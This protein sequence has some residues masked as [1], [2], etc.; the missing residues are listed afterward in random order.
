MKTAHSNP[1]KQRGRKGGPPPMRSLPTPPE[2]EKFQN[3]ISECGCG[4][5][6]PALHGPRCPSCDCD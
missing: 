4:E 2:V 3:T 6:Y 5:R 1:R